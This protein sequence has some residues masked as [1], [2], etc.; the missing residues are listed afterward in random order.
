VLRKL[1]PVPNTT[2][3]NCPRKPG[4]RPPP[5]PAFGVG[6]ANRGRIAPLSTTQTPSLVPETTCP[7]AITAQP[8]RGGS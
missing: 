6:L 5:A 7:K 2:S 3:G 8:I 4:I 1:S